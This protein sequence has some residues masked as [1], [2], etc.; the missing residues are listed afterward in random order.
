[1]LVTCSKPEDFLD[2]I[3][4]ADT[5]T[6]LVYQQEICSEELGVETNVINRL[7]G[8][9]CTIVSVWGNTLY[10]VN[11]LPFKPLEYYPHI[12]GAFR[13]KTSTVKVRDLK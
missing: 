9:G 11:D 5:Q 13:Q 4:T 3:V 6:T 8:K 12:Y 10:H 7:K 1:M 2:S